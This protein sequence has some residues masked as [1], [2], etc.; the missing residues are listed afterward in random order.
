[1]TALVPVPVRACLRGA[2]AGYA[3]MVAAA[4]AALVASLVV[5]FSSAVTLQEGLAAGTVGS[6]AVALICLASVPNAVLCAGAYLAGPGF[7]LGSGT[8]VAPGDVELGRLPALPILAAIPTSGEPR[9]WDAVLICVPVLAG[10]VAGLVAWR[11]DPVYGLDQAAL[12]G[13]ASA[14]VGGTAFGLSTWLATGA[15]GP[16]RMQDIGPNVL[17][18]TAVC[19]LAF[20]VGGAVAAGAARW[21]Q[22]ARSGSARPL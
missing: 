19:G 4:A 11:R 1:V 2:L 5:H 8:T 17:A 20:L 15:I 7:V 6:I 9:W 12:R 14:F 18:T 21:W 10:A 3:A 16:G 13:A 22:A